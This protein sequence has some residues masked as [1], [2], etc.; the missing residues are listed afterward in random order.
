MNDYPLPVLALILWALLA[1]GRLQAQHHVAE[2]NLNGMALR[3]VDGGWLVEEVPQPLPPNSLLNAGDIILKLAGRSVS[4]M[5]ALSTA[6]LLE[7]DR[8]QNLPVTVERAG[9]E[10]TF[11]FFGDSRPINKDERS[12]LGATLRTVEDTERIVVADV[13]TGSPAEQAGLKNDDELISLDGNQVGDLNDTADR[14]R[15]A[16]H[17]PVHLQVRRDGRMLSITLKR[18]LSAPQSKSL[19]PQSLPFPLHFRSEPAPS[20][21]LPDL[22]GKHVS[23]RDYQ[24]KPVLLTFWGTWCLPCLLESD[25]LEKL[26]REL[27]RQMTVLA[28]NVQDDPQAVRNFLQ[29][30]KLSYRVLMAGEFASP[31]CEAYD[32]GALP[33]TILID[34]K[35]FITYLQLGVTPNLPLESRARTLVENSVQ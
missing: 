34:S 21:T 26:N 31:V 5:G 15:A 35:G 23:L 4:Q 16:E 13:A 25:Q 10:K 2:L 24:G 12:A 33:L 6:A 30:R 7:Y 19:R 20:F 14:L 32:V 8:A 9:K 22:D 11:A 28:L 3:E 17:T 1:P 27:G 29:M 18:S